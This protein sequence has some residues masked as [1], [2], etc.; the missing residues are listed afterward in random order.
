MHAQHNLPL[1]TSQVYKTAAA[2]A[3]SRAAGEANA[4]EE[5]EET[6]NSTS[7]F[8]SAPRRYHARMAAETRVAA[9]QFQSPGRTVG[10]A[11][12]VAQAASQY[13]ME[14][15]D[16]EATALANDKAEAA[17]RTERAA[18]LRAAAEAVV[19]DVRSAKLATPSRV[20]ASVD[21]SPTVTP[22]QS[23]RATAQSLRATPLA[24]ASTPRRS[25][26]L[27]TPARVATSVDTSPIVTPCHSTLAAAQSSRSLR[28][29]R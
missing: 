18:V 21:A 5:T 24:P 4:F 17:E 14:K 20:A 6:V 19:V 12:A 2:K 15:R 3:E 1:L 22:R 25:A 28:S 7:E 29:R 27:V 11:T 23:A 8:E 26:R 16:A 9:T 13:T 10:T